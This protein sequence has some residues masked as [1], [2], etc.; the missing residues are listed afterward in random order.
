MD[1][2]LNSV[3]SL[4][5]CVNQEYICPPVLENIENIGFQF[6][7]RLFCLIANYRFI[8]CVC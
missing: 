8:F 4:K 1:E 5:T 7:E 3:R 2:N 6:A